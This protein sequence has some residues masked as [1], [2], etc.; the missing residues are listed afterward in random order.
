MSNSTHWYDHYY[1]V[2]ELGEH[3][4]NINYFPNQ[5]AIINFFEKPHHYN[6]EWEEYQEYL[7]GDV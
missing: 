4:V 1:K 6:Q 5:R 3:L 2:V 7:R